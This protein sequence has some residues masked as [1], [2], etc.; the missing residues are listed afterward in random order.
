[1]HLFG[2]LRFC[3]LICRRFHHS[4]LVIV[5]LSLLTMQTFDLSLGRHYTRVH[6]HGAHRAGRVS[7]AHP[8]QSN[9]HRHL[10]GMRPSATVLSLVTPVIGGSESLRQT[11]PLPSLTQ[12]PSDLPSSIDPSPVRL[13]L[14]DRPGTPNLNTSSVQLIDS[15]SPS[16]SDQTSHHHRHSFK[17]FNFSSLPSNGGKHIRSLDYRSANGGGS[18]S[19]F[20]SEDSF[21]M[22]S[23]PTDPQYSSPSRQCSI[24]TSQPRQCANCDVSYETFSSSSAPL[25]EV[26]I[27]LLA[28]NIDSLPYSLNKLLPALLHAVRHVQQTMS[29]H[30]S[31]RTLASLSELTSTSASTST[32]TMMTTAA[33]EIDPNSTEHTKNV[34][35]SSSQ[36]AIPADFR[37]LNAR[38]RLRVYYR[39]TNCSSSLGPLAAFDF[40]TEQSV[41]AFFGPFCDYVL[42]P[43][44]RYASAW[45]VPVLTTGGQNDNFDSKRLFYPLLTRMNGSYTQMGSLL[46]QILHK[47]QWTVIAMLFHNNRRK[48]LGN[49]A[50]YFKLG[51]IF[52]KL[53]RPNAHY[54][55]SFDETD[56]AT[57]Y[58]QVL[59]TASKSARSKFFSFFSFY[60]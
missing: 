30:V 15:S 14:Y 38:Y 49:S 4:P 7:T 59:R 28:P 51:A 9:P 47:F 40:Y 48:Q 21:R 37:P 34:N 33:S 32:T 27:A 45:N 12:L 26:Q 20:L 29:L 56:P 35:S 3:R 2:R 53:Q 55:D 10:H 36:P 8:H 39:N 23:N 16:M 6:S 58:E 57:D 44:T 54:H 50:C 24:A 13:H 22:S 42:A 46:L 41:H 18:V 31:S 11:L 17:N 52:S 19:P 25:Q 60:F 1:M 5:L 43:V